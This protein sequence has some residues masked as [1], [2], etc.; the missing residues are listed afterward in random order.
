MKT[1]YLDMDGVLVD[2]QPKVQD[3]RKYLIEFTNYKGE[4]VNLTQQPDRVDEVP[5]LF[6]NLPPMKGAIDSFKRLSEIY[7]I[8]I[9]STAPWNNP[10][11]W[12]YKRMW[13]EEHLGAAATKRLILSH[14]KNLMIGHYLVDDRTK[15]GAGD[16]TGE[17]LLF[18]GSD[19]PDWKTTLEYLE[20]NA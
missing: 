9:L 7:D 4:V 18:G 2:I 20:N 19:F 16:F 13:V 8:Y 5:F 17:H 1:L 11:A 6:E 12:L 3:I 10:D 15:N 14:H